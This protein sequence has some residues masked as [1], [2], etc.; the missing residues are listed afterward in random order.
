M[1]LIVFPEILEQEDRRDEDCQTA[2]E[3]QT[4]GEIYATN[5]HITGEMK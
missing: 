3:L 1:P 5:Q 2:R 4:A